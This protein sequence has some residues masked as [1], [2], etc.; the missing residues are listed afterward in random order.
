MNVVIV[1]CRKGM[2]GHL[3]GG[4]G[5]GG[6][7]G[8]KLLL[9]FTIILGPCFQ[10]MAVPYDQMLVPKSVLKWSTAPL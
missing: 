3:F 10:L 6:G 1:S 8:G 7:G 2:V 9:G 5:G 4:G